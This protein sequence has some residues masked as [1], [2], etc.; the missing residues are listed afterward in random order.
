M[1]DILSQMA[2]KLYCDQIVRLPRF[3]SELNDDAMSPPIFYFDS[4]YH[5]G[6][7]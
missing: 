1:Q 3:A 7:R 4:L 5:T 2:I 6:G